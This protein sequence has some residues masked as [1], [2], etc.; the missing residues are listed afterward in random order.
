MTSV[1]QS[2]HLLGDT[3]GYFHSLTPCPESDDTVHV[4]MLDHTYKTPPCSL[5]PEPLDHLDPF[6]LSPFHL[7]T[8]LDTHLYSFREESPDSYDLLMSFTFP[9]VTL[10]SAAS[11][12]SDETL[13]DTTPSE[14][15][16][17]N[18]QELLRSTRWPGL[19]NHV[20][21]TPPPSVEAGS[22]GEEGGKT[23]A[24]KFRSL[25]KRIKK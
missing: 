12:S 18:Q 13:Y 3:L 4:E 2:Y 19:Q 14:L 8:H 10:S 16:L 15:E 21:L 20:T 25:V 7:D 17:E 11:W 23:L 5:L 22:S 1:F 24:A 9:E 6:H